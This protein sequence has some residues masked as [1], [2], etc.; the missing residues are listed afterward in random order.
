[1]V[2]QISLVYLPGPLA[3][4][5]PGIADGHKPIGWIRLD[6]GEA[7][8]VTARDRPLEECDVNAIKEL[9]EGAGEPVPADADEFRSVGLTPGG[10]SPTYFLFEAASYPL[11]LRPA[12]DAT[13][14]GRRLG[15]NVN[16]EK[17]LMV[18]SAIN[19]AEGVDP[20]ISQ[21]TIRGLD[22]PNTIDDS[23]T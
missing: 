20:G 7:L 3:D 6:N 1:M 10:E 18:I 8:W 14:T 22:G 12:P 5:W 17:G 2:T 13:R 16:R 21:I 4:W 15:W 9:H 19:A 23:E 11:D